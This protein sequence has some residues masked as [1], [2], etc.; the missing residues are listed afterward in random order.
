M[1]NSYRPTPLEPTDFTGIRDTLEQDGVCVIQNILSQSDQATFLGLFWEAM[2]RR[3]KKLRRD[4]SA[5]WVEDNTDWYGTF[6]AGQ[7]K[8]YGMAQEE[9]CWHI[10]GNVTI[11][12]IFEEG[13]FAQDRKKEDCCVSLDGCAALFR[14]CTSGLKLHVD[15]VPD[16]DGWEWGSIQG[17]YNLY[18][19]DVSADQTRANAGFACVVGSHRQYSHWWEEET[20]L[21]GFKKP[22]KHWYTIREDSPLQKQ[23]QIILSPANSLVLWRSD[24]LHKNYG[25]DY[26]TAELGTPE[27]PRLARLTQ[28]VTFQPMRFRTEEVKLR[29][30]QSVVDGVCNNHWAALSFR[31]PVTPFPAWSAAS[32]KIPIKLPFGKQRTKEM[33][34]GEQ[35]LKSEDAAECDSGDFNM[36]AAESTAVEEGPAL[37]RRKTGKAG[38]LEKALLSL[39][40]YVQDLL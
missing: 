12:K 17:A 7:Y 27:T 36:T 24:L 9:H 10:R 2:Q 34:A 39:P 11:R 26:T 30:A 19:V 14:P 6:G 29:K 8:H 4:D 13:V 16:V 21:K 1:L 28:F 33:S 23:L 15:A 5:T 32:K 3:N 31:V 18:A 38:E 22:T 35:S 37:K 20:T 25:G 40:A